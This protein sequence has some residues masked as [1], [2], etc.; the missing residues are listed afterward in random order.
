M[1]EQKLTASDGLALDELGSSVA[2]TGD[3]ALVGAQGGDGNSGSAY[4]YH[5]DGSTIGK[6]PRRSLR[7]N[8]SYG[9]PASSS[10]PTS[11]GVGSLP[12]SG[13]GGGGGGEPGMNPKLRM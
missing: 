7:A 6:R 11:S 3:F 4:V 10:H 5:F 12:Q 9:H 13:Y 1:E 2:L 8:L